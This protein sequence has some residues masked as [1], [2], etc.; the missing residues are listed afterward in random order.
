M[1]RSKGRGDGFDGLRVGGSLG[2][3]AVGGWGL[4]YLAYVSSTEGS[5]G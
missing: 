4:G 1:L 3:E 5:K 2:K